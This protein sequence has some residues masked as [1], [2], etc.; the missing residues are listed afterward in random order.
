[1]PICP[2]CNGLREVFLL[3]TNCGEPMMEAGRLMDFYENYSPYM[4]I[5]LV[6]M[7]DGYTETNSEQICPHLFYCSKC[8]NDEVIFIKE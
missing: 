7:E 1:M 4:E 2:V 6:K 5:D 3:C 8:H